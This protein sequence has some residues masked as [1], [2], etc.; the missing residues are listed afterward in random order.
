MNFPA[1]AQ[2]HGDLL[3]L[4]KLNDADVMSGHHTVR[5]VTPILDGVR[6]RFGCCLVQLWSVD[7]RREQLVLM[8]ESCDRAIEQW[9]VGVIPVAGTLTGRAFETR[10]PQ[11][12]NRPV[13]GTTAEPAASF[14]PTKLADQPASGRSSPCP[15]RTSATRIRSPS[16]STFTSPTTER[17]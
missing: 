6:K 12:H 4:V 8:A 14:W 3:G 10:Q 7:P 13:A 5:I 2:W 15:W 17:A 9:T 11:I 1:D 16:S